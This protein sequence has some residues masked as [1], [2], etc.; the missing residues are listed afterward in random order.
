M[1]LTVTQATPPTVAQATPPTVT[2][3]DPPTVAQATPPFIALGLLEVTCDSTTSGTVIIDDRNAWDL[4]TP[5][6]DSTTSGSVVIDD[7]TVTNLAAAQG[8]WVPDGLHNNGSGKV[9]KW[10]N[11]GTG[12]TNYDLLQVSAGADPTL[13]ATANR[14]GGPACTLVRATPTRLATIAFTLNAPNT[15]IWIAKTTSSTLN[16]RLSDGRAGGTRTF[17]Q[18][19]NF[20]N[21]GTLA[22]TVN[23]V[24]AGTWYGWAAVFNGASSLLSVGTD[25]KTGDAGSSVASGIVL[26]DFGLDTGAAFD[27]TVERG[28]FWTRALSA[29]EIAAINTYF[30]V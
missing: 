20:T 14:S 21:A 17:F 29:G 19:N 8:A 15:Q 28:Y 11:S 23:N 10:T 30:G 25:L 6:A 24:V 26:G 3:A 18:F 5:S 9:D 2:G 13:S 22:G 27:G 7:R 4:A 16:Q 1:K 12:G